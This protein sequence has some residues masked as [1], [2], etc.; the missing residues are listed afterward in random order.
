MIDGVPAKVL[1]ENV[2]WDINREMTW[3]KY[4]REPH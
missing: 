2:D 1:K 3:E 4:E